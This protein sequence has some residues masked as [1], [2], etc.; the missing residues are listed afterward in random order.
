MTQHEAMAR[1][2][3]F[4][5]AEPTL[6]VIP[7]DTPTEKLRVRHGGYDIRGAV[8][9]PN[10]A[11]PLERMRELAREER[12]GELAANAYS[13]VGACAQTPLLKHT[14]PEWVKLLQSQAVDA[15][16]MVPV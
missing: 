3:A 15:V 9:D 10:V 13:F 14:G 7:V 2:D 11:F 4:L 8:A 5:K 16:V 6:S 1:V 12:I